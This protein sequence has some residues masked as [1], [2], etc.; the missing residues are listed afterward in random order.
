M[1][2][3]ERLGATVARVPDP[4]YGTHAKELPETTIN[5]STTAGP[6][7]RWVDIPKA[8]QRNDKYQ[9]KCKHH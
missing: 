4:T 2:F 1:R 3:L 6:H 7:G 9:V 5:I 8:A